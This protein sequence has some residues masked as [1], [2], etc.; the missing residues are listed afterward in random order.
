MKGNP[1]TSGSILAALHVCEE[2]KKVMC[3]EL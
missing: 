2:M 1:G 3:K